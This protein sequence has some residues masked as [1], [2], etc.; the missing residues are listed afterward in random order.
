MVF[1]VIHVFLVTAVASGSAAA[2]P[3]IA[4]EAAQNPIG[5]PALL[6][7]TLPTSANFYLTYFLVQGFTSASDNLLN[8]SDLV[9]YLLSD[10]VLDKTPRQKYNRFTS[11]KSMAWGKNFPKFTNFAIIGKLSP[12]Y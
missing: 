4:R 7:N 6:A 10:Y 9:V 11:L 3:V 12:F 2:I 1:Q 8:Y 5:V